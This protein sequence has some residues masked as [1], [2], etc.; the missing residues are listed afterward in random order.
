MKVKWKYV[1]KKI[2]NFY[3]KFLLENYQSYIVKK[4]NHLIKTKSKGKCSKNFGYL[5]YYIYILCS[6]L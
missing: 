5:L 4:L 3:S 2:V 6:K 1:A